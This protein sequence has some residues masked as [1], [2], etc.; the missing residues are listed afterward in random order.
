MSE[1]TKIVQ[2]GLQKVLGGFFEKDASI[3]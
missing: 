2:L 3:A 1:R